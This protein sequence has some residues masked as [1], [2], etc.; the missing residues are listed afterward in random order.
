[1][2]GKEKLWWR[3]CIKVG[4]KSLGLYVHGG[5]LEYIGT[6]RGF[7]KSQNNIFQNILISFPCGKPW[8]ATLV[9]R[10]LLW[11]GNPHP[12][13][14]VLWAGRKKKQTEGGG[15][16]FLH[17]ERGQGKKTKMRKKS[18]LPPPW[19]LSLFLQVTLCNAVLE[20]Y[21][22]GSLPMHFNKVFTGE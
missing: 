10:P 17:T 12:P 11:W 14:L 15:V 5:A 22:K 8:M 18:S 19:M 1:M 2:E 7:Q 6:S 9:M 13:L 16:N 4:K 3:L 20:G 21:G